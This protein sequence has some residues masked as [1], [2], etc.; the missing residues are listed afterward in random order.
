MQLLACIWAPTGADTETKIQVSKLHHWI[1]ES[2][3]PLQQ[4]AR[5][6]QLE[7]SPCLPKLE[8]SPREI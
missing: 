8:E 3:K 6:L 7:S 2:E 4:E 1:P 5:I